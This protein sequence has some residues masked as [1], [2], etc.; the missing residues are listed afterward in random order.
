MM[1]ARRSRSTLASTRSPL[2]R[3]PDCI[4]PVWTKWPVGLLRQSVTVKTAEPQTI[5][6]V[7]PTWPPISA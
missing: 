3:T 5:S 1:E 7:S 4:R 2:V 6:P